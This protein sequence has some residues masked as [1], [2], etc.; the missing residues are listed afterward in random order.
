MDVSFSTEGNREDPI[1]TRIADCVLALKILTVSAK[2]NKNT[3]VSTK[4]TMFC[5]ACILISS[6]IPIKI[7][8]AY[9][10]VYVLGV[11]KIEWTK[12][13]LHQNRQA[14]KYKQRLYII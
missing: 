13:R 2:Q 8:A 6:F 1:D 11:N 14:L 5:L 3:D 10:V 12:P 9:I 7:S 4:Q